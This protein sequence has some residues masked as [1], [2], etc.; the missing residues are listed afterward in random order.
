MRALIAFAA[1]A[2]I[3]AGCSE[4]DDLARGLTIGRPAKV[5]DSGQEPAP[6]VHVMDFHSPDSSRGNVCPPNSGSFGSSGGFDAVTKGATSDF[7][8]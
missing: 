2:M 5:S 3:F 8:L 4:P 1:T 6:I 7:C